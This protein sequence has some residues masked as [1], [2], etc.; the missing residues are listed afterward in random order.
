M[1]TRGLGDNFRRRRPGVFTNTLGIRGRRS[2]GMNN[3]RSFYSSVEAVQSHTSYIQGE[4][5]ERQKE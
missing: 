3:K 1:K 2:E 5:E 4:G